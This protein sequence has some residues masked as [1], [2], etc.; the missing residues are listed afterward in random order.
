MQLFERCTFF[1]VPVFFFDE[2]LENETGVKM[3]PM[4]MVFK[5]CMSK[6]YFLTFPEDLCGKVK[7]WWQNFKKRNAIFM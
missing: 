7:I 2:E 1:K 5:S 4:Y 3:K 6:L